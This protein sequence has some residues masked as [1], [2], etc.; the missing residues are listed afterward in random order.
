VAGR[1]VV[2]APETSR[3]P[4]MT[5]E[6]LVAEDDPKPFVKPE[7]P[8]WTQKFGAPDLSKRPRRQR[9]PAKA[10]P[11]TQERIVESSGSRLAAYSELSSSKAQDTEQATSSSAVREEASWV[12][13]DCKV[14]NSDRNAVVCSCCGD[15]NPHA[16][17][18]K[19][20]PR[21]Q[22]LAPAQ[23]PVDAAPTVQSDQ[24]VSPQEGRTFGQPHQSIL[25]IS[26]TTSGASSSRRPSHVPPL[27]LNVVVPG[28]GVVPAAGHLHEVSYKPAGQPPPAADFSILQQM[29]KTAADEY[30][31]LRSTGMAGAIDRARTQQARLKAEYSFARQSISNT[32]GVGLGN[33]R[34]FETAEARGMSIGYEMLREKEE[35]WK[36]LKAHYEDRVAGV[37]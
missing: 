8:I 9:L 5:A 18:P 26:T 31:E 14:R 33:H 21:Y 22:E 12:C 13:E 23:Q 25:H 1:Q 6:D 32:S 7:L 3:S 19:P 35:R 36:L 34:R 27:D 20:K 15:T 37:E 4:E 10:A 30:E 2:A 29:K 24:L 11:K 16:P 28:L 17:K